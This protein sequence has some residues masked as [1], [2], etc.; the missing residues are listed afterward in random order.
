MEEGSEP[1]ISHRTT[2]TLPK[3]T[4]DHVTANR[5]LSR[6]KKLQWLHCWLQ[7]EVQDQKVDR[8]EVRR[9]SRHANEQFGGQQAT[10]GKDLLYLLTVLCK[11]RHVFA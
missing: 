2:M 3:E 1:K 10:K 11:D 9:I 6:L 8:H 7:A 4:T 5:A